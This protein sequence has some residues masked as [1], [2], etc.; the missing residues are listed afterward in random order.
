MC[1]FH[2]VVLGSLHL[3]GDV[4]L[5]R[6]DV[7]GSDLLRPGALRGHVIVSLSLSVSHH[8]SDF[9]FT[10][11]PRYADLLVA[12]GFDL[13]GSLGSLLR[14]LGFLPSLRLELSS[15]LQGRVN[16]L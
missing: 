13:R 10:F 9:A 16:P 15:A 6:S 2:S 12:V 5:D 7:V 3:L 14:I 8:V 11:I 4:G 1:A